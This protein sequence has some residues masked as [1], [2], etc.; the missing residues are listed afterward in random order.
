[1][2]RRIIVTLVAALAAAASGI[3]RERA[4]PR[5]E[6]IAVPASPR[7]AAAPG[8]MPVPSAASASGVISG[9]VTSAAGG[10]PIRGATVILS[11]AVANRRI[12]TDARGAFQFTGLVPGLFTIEAAR[13]GYLANR[14]GQKTPGGR[15]API[16]LVEG[17]RVDIEVRLSR[18]ARSPGSSSMSSASRS[19]ARR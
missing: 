9:V 2:I 8:Q 13:D 19:S 5:P 17:Q 4:V 6:Q 16:E 14:Y 18:A 10:R 3:A 1:M 7:G 15:G 11:G 12:Q